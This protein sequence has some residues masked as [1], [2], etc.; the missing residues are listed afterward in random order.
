MKIYAV[1]HTNCKTSWRGISQW[2]GHHTDEGFTAFI[3]R[4]DAQFVANQCNAQY[5]SDLYRVVTFETD[6]TGKDGRK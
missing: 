4:K 2:V 5:D 6:D 3:R 1:M